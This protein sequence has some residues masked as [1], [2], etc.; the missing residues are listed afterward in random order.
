[1]DHEIS[2][3]A[4]IAVSLALAVVLGFAAQR[5]RLPPVLGYLLAGVA[6]GLVLPGSVD[7]LLAVRRVAVPEAIG[8]VA[9]ATLSGIGLAMT[10]DWSVGA[11]LVFGL[12]LSVAST[13]VLLRAPGER[14]IREGDPADALYLVVQ[15][16]AEVTIDSRK[17]GTRGP[18]EFFGEMAL[19]TGDRRTAD[20]TALDYSRFAR[21]SRR[22]FRHLLRR[23]P[24][25]RE[26]IE[27]LAQERAN[28]SRQLLG[29]QG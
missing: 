20:V 24:A 10:W 27:Q 15:G 13:V 4:T 28:A 12:S 5:L 2:L 23:Y 29:G 3:I 11:G 19:L 16:E 25:I 14:I 21:L 1:M 6:I 8:Q 18:G 17:V 7:D 22:D 9:F 26:Q